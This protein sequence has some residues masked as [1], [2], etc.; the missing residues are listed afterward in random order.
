LLIV[1]GL[2]NTKER[3]MRV[4]TTDPI[5]GMDVID[6]EHAPFAIDDRGDDM[7]KIFFNSYENRQVYDYIVS[8][9]FE[10][11]ITGR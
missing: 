4:Q 8:N 10:S 5:N 2:N 3:Y 6:I 1:P 11:H 9:Q 7:I